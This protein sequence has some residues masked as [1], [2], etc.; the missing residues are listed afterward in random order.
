[1]NITFEQPYQV[2]LALKDTFNI[3][4]VGCGGT[5]GYIAETIARIAWDLKQTAKTLTAIF[6]DPDTVE[7]KTLVVND[8]SRPSWG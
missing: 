1:M 6:V 8:L 3:I 5:G 7:E 4:L 2:I